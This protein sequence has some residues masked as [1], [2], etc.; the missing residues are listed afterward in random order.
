[1]GSTEHKRFMQQFTE[2][3]EENGIDTGVC[4]SRSNHIERTHAQ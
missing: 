2:Y 4:R 1:M 3:K